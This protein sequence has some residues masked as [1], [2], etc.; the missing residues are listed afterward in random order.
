[1]KLELF[2]G[3]ILCGL[4]TMLFVGRLVDKFKKIDKEIELPVSIAVKEYIMIFLCGAVAYQGFRIST[5]VLLFLGIYL[6]FMAYTDY[7]TKKVYSIFS[8]LMFVAGAVCLFMTTTSA[9]GNLYS[10]LAFVVLVLFGFLIKAYAFGDVEIYIALYPY[11]ALYFFDMPEDLLSLMLWF[12]VTLFITVIACVVTWFL[13]R[14]KNSNSGPDGF[15]KERKAMAPVIAFAHVLLL[16]MN[17][18]G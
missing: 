15:S 16:C 14:I 12:A 2:F 1:M 3:V 10:L 7:H 9:K 11:Y 8:Y 13:S 6:A 4:F 18:F 5:I 17:Y